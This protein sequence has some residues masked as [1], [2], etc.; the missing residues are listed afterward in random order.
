MN[1]TQIAW[2]EK[3]WNPVTGCQVCTEGCK[4]CYARE[5]AE[6][7]RGT[8]AFPLGFD[9]H[10]RPK[11]LT[12]PDS[13]AEPSHIFVNSMS[14]VFWEKIPNDYRHRIL[15]TIERNP[16]HQFQVLTKRPE[17]MLEFSKE[18]KFPPNMWAGVSLELQKYTDRVD[19]LRQVDAKIR[20]ISA[21]PLLGP[22]ELDL[23]GIHWQIV[24]GES[25]SHIND[26]AVAEKRALV[27]LS[28]GKWVPQ[29]D[30]ATWVY[31]LREQAKKAG[32]A[33]F[34]KQWGGPKSKSGGCDL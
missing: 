33:F 2:T 9:L 4:Y 29:E 17:K 18:R 19:I 16:H 6:N 26:A 23:A 15:D 8:A 11:K 25:G 22:L 7:K 5:L 34:F 1:N 3:T 31:S 28:E 24:G 12:E 10:L 27:K 30:K 14:D 21:E 32:T 20:F 13:I